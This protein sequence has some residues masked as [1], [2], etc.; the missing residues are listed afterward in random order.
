MARSLSLAIYGCAIVVS[1][2]TSSLWR[3]PV[4]AKVVSNRSNVHLTTA[5]HLLQ[6][7]GQVDS[8]TAA[9]VII[10]SDDDDL[11]G[12]TIP[13][14]LE[15]ADDGDGDNIPNPLTPLDGSNNG[16]ADYLEY[17]RRLHLP[18]IAR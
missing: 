1:V 8:Q 6:P 15:Q 10:S 12:D 13:D 11:D 5:Q 9:T 16:I 18:L 2:L 3:Y 7:T 14:N 4:S 17:E